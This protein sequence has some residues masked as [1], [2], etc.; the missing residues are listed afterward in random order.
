[1]S[2]V[3]RLAGAILAET[4]GAFYLVGNTKTP[5]DFAAHGFEKPVEI[6][7]LKNPTLRLSPLREV[8]LVPPYLGFE[9]EGEPLARALAAR[10]LIERTGSVSDRLWRLVVDSS[11]AAEVTDARWLG[12]IPGPI[13]DIV[14]ERVLKCS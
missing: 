4:E 2:R 11:G 6:D 10:F 13:W 8:S 9:L 1:M 5:C 12:E 3:G 14:R 7:A